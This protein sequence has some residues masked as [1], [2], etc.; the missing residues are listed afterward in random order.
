MVQYAVY[1]TVKSGRWAAESGGC[2]EVSGTGCVLLWEQQRG[3]LVG[4]CRDGEMTA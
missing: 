1:N 2:K 4:A 3:A